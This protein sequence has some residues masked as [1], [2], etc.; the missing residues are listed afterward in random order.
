M[1]R[2]SKDI[3]KDRIL[4]LDGAMGTMIQ[5]YKL[6]EADYRGERFADYPSDLKGNN[7]LLSLTQPDIIKDIHRAYLNAGADI[8]ETNT[9]SGTTIAMAD[10]DMQDLVWELN[11]QSA[12]IAK[13]A[14]EEY[15][16]KP[17]FVAGSIGPTN[18]TASL[19]PDVNRPGFRAI[20]FDELKI[21]YKQQAEALAV[22][23][24]D[25][26]LVETVFDTLNCKAALMAIQEL[27]DEKGI[28]IPVMVSGTI[29]DASGRTLSGQTVGAFWNSIRHFPLLSV[30]FNCALGA[31]QLKV[32]LQQLARISDVAISCH[33]NAGLPNEFGEYDE[34][35]S[36]MSSIIKSYFDEGLVNI[37]GGCC[38]TQPEHIKAIADYAAQSKPHKIA[39]QQKLMRLSGLEP[40]SIT[41]ELNFVNIGERTNVSGS[42]KFARLIREEKFEEAVDIAIDQVEGGAQIIDINMDDG[43]LDAVNVLPNFVNLIASEPDIARLPF[44]IDSSKWEVIEAGLK[45]LQ[46][47][48]IVNSISLKEGEEDLIAKAKKIKSYGAAVVVMA[49][50]ETGQADTFD[51][52][53]EVCKRC[54]D[55]L[56]NE[57]QFPAEDIIFDPNILTIGTGMEEHNNYAVDFIEAVKWIKENLPNAKTSGGV[58]NISF[59]FRGNNV[60]REAMH[61]AFLYHAIK[62]GLDMG[63]VNP[64]MLEVYDEIDKELLDYVEDLLFNR[65]ADATERLMSYAENLKPGEKAEKAMQEWRNLHVNKRLEHALI[66]GITEYIEED[67]EECRLQAER[68][69]DVIE[70]PLMDGMNVVGDLFGSGKMFLPQVVKSARVMKKAVAYLLPYIEAAKDPKAKSGNGRIL[71]ATVKGDVHDIGKNIVSVVLACNNY[72]I[73]DLGVMVPL[74]KI[75]EEAEKHQVDIIGLSGLI[76]PS[77]DEMIYVAEEMEKRGLKTPVMIGGATTSRIHTAVKIKPNYTG[78]VI[79]VNDASRSVTVAGK[80]LGKDKEDFYAEIVKE[81][82]EAK[83]GHGKRSEAKNYVSIEEARANKYQ[84]DWENYKPHAPQKIGSEVLHDYD[85]KEIAE[86]ID[87]TP[88]FQTWEMKGRYPKILNDPEKGVEA[89]KLF[90]DAQQMLQDIIDNKQLTANAIFGLYPAHTKNHDSIEVF[91]DAKK[92]EKLTEFHTLRQQN[93]KGE[94]NPNYAFSDFLAPS[95]ANYTDYVGCFAVTTGIG[96]DKMTAKYEADHDDYSSIMAKALADRLAEAFAELLHKK[97]RTEYWGYAKDETLDNEGLIREQYKGIRPAP[98]YPGCPD[99]TEKITLFNLLEVE[100]NTGISLT[101]NLAMWPTASVSGFYFGHPESRYF[102]LGK[103]GKDQVED[104]AKRKNQS[105]E[106][107]ERWLRPNLNY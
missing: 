35:P 39:P 8:I 43:M 77:L 79:H 17:R 69:L 82:E 64:G 55:L 78:P 76:T 72:E 84:T 93:K 74:Q 75:L 42:K 36:Q 56:V 54:Y 41:P 67:T 44:M 40:L 18:R 10:Y 19:S 91:A 81:Y 107:I 62:A 5:N 2:F 23:G 71:M 106:D 104:I 14:T 50:D 6:T 34:S 60:V 20:S 13:E 80:L 89:Q 29:T 103:I 61:S 45:C 30:G 48:G 51:R 4:V 59:S 105:F 47:K 65:R 12:K 52:K 9:F 87:W 58:S 32:Y 16:D 99:H 11:E 86:Y 33:P 68:P 53:V 38:G 24:V 28:D 73:I 37:I 92:T 22:G 90:D 70:G 95:E 83:A 26:F 100:K 1:S 97:V 85:L 25:I 57:A 102:G 63:I 94:K 46:G 7:D 15:S 101:E 31:D 96:L 49:F 3:L 88:F 66:K 27:N 98:G 21:A